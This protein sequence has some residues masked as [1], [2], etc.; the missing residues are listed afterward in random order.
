MDVIKSVLAN[1]PRLSSHQLQL[2]PMR[3]RSIVGEDCLP[4]VA[5]SG[6]AAA[7]RGLT[8]PRRVRLA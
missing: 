4:I 7:L 2:A 5:A 1:G 6:L 8:C 3:V